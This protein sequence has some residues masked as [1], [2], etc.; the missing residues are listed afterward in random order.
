MKILLSVTFIVMILSSSQDDD[1]HEIPVSCDLESVISNEKY[2]NTPSDQL[3]INSLAINDNCLQINFSSSGCDGDTWELELVVS[4]W[5]LFS[6]PPQRNLR[7]S[8]Q[9]EE[10]CQAVITKELTL[11]ISNLQV[12]GNEVRLNI[13][14]SDE[15]IMYK[16]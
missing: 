13:T 3:T 1:G 14:N 2:E 7:L 15:S 16:Y 5:I 4:E 9:N 10:L 11:D 6:I 12:N 8:L